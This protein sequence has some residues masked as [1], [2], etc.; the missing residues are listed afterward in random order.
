LRWL[1][2]DA[3]RVAALTTQPAGCEAGGLDRQVMLGK[4]AFE[5]PALLGGAAGRMELACSSC[6]LNGRGNPAFLLEGVSDKAGTADVTSSIFSKVRGN[7]TFDPKPIPDIALRDG[8]QIADRKGFE[9]RAKV[10]GLVVEEFD[11]QEPPAQVFEA[12]LAYLDALGPGACG[13]E[14]QTALM[15]RELFGAE[16]AYDA[17]RD[18]AGELEVEA[19]L[20][21]LRAARLRLSLIHE[22]Y[23]A[24]GHAA[25]R[26]RLTAISREMGGMAE[27]I[28]TGARFDAAAPDWNDLAGDLLAAQGTSLY[29][30]EALRAALAAEKPG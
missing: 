11:G 24:P 29:D 26:A 18:G 5:S 17:A 23:G 13:A 25:L 10:H 22:R 20:F 12:L 14:E 9:F 30:P 4:I 15:E 21:Y 1:S 27:A 16:A 8:K 2:K 3:D 7:Q 6:H 19:R 28:R